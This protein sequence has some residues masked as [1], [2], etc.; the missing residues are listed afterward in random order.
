MEIEGTSRLDGKE[1]LV[2]LDGCNLHLE[3]RVSIHDFSVHDKSQ[4]V[5][6]DLSDKLSD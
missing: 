2:R 6:K 1:D 3:Q 4:V 5:N